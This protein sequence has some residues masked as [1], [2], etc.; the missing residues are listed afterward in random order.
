MNAKLS[1]PAAELRDRYGIIVI[2]SGYGGSIA[3]ARLAASGHE[4]CILER[5][6]EWIPGEFPDAID[7]VTA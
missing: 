3:A 4:V 2:G 6:K 7:E 1:S 5:G